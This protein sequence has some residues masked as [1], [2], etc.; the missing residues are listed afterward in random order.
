MFEDQKPNWDNLMNTFFK[1]P[2]DELAR[3]V[4]THNRENGFQY[5]LGK[6]RPFPLLFRE[7]KEEEKQ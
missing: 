2:K 7:V 6:D 1:C 4:E 3:R 5:I